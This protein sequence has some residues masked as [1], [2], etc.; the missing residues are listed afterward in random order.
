MTAPVKSNSSPSNA[1][2][3]AATAASASASWTF[4]AGHEAI[5][6]EAQ[7]AIEAAASRMSTVG[8]PHA[9]D[10]VTVIKRSPRHV[11]WR[12]NLAQPLFVKLYL[13]EPRRAQR[14]WE[15]SVATSERGLPVPSP[16]AF[17]SWHDTGQRRDAVVTEFRARGVT[18]HAMAAQLRGSPEAAV[19]FASDLGDFVASLHRAGYLHGDFHLGN[20]L[21]ETDD[22]DCDDEDPD[23]AA[24]FPT[25]L[26]SITD[27]GRAQLLPS[28][29]FHWGELFRA[30]RQPQLIDLTQVKFDDNKPSLQSLGAP[31]PL[32]VVLTQYYAP[33]MSIPYV[34]SMNKRY[35]L[36]GTSYMAVYEFGPKIRS[37]SVLNFGQSGDPASPHYFDQAKL[38]SEKKLKTD[39]FDW[40]DV[41]AG[42]KLVYHPGEP[43]LGRVAQ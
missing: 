39:L 7:T 8:E 17:G 24:P 18:A 26:I 21:V 37:A 15:L 16:V 34:V 12:L 4:R 42:A 30:Q 28:L 3:G 22:S 35:G 36:V 2:P 43:P 14:E 38:L 29:S 1:P 20:L 5:G 9:S 23:G 6:R 25:W 11:C 27:H 32:G 31:G 40:D 10:P 13:A 41:V 33:S 19:Q